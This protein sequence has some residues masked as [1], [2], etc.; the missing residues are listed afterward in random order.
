MIRSD[1]RSI[2]KGSLTLAA[3]TA[4]PAALHARPA[5]P[6]LV[7]Y[8][9]RFENSRR[10][11]AHWRMQGVPAIDPRENDLGIAWRDRIP[12]LIAGGGGIEGA[13]LWSDQFICERFGADF[14]LRPVSA[15]QQGLPLD[16]GGSLRRW[17]LA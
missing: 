6:A 13:T 3:L 15:E 4:A 11:A 7:V 16:A 14:G 17:R 12:R 2:L 9:M 1:R 5:A 10:L 8:D